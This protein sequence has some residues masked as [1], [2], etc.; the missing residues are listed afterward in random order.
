M[1]N[2]VNEF[3]VKSIKKFF[4][5][6]IGKLE[7]MAM[8]ENMVYKQIEKTRYLNKQLL[9]IFKRCDIVFFSQNLIGI[10][11]INSVFFLISN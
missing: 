7:V 1:L 10:I 4:P 9:S 11:N 3:I 8:V 5:F 2:Y 6:D